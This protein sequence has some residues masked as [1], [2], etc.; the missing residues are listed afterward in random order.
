M[1][2]KGGKPY[3]APEDVEVAAGRGVLVSY[4]GSGFRGMGAAAP[5]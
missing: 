1:S 4:I 3:E 2:G 5:I